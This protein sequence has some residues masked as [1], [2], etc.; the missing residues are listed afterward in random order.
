MAEE[1]VT[2]Q[3][4][5][6]DNP[7]VD[8]AQSEQ[9]APETPVDPEEQIEDLK[10]NE[11]IFNG[12]NSS[13]FNP[14]VSVGITHPQY[15]GREITLQGKYFDNG[16]SLMLE[17]VANIDMLLRMKKMADLT[18]ESVKEMSVDELKEMLNPDVRFTDQ[19]RTDYRKAWIVAYCVQNVLENGEVIMDGITPTQV[20]HH[21]PKSMIEQVYDVFT[22]G[23]TGSEQDTV[24]MFSFKV[25]VK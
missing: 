6:S 22:Q 3:D 11:S 19:Q 16:G 5:D 15:P 21:F 14:D 23:V 25:E 7:D 18:P 12:S 10:N 4:I 2:Y 13:M 1:T 20:Q 17:D 24:D 8:N 9:N